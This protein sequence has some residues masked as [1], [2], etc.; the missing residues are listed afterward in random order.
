MGKASASWESRWTGTGAIEYVRSLHGDAVIEE[1]LLGEEFTLQAFV[2]G[3]HLVPMPLVQDHKRAF[4]GD[5]GPNT[6]G[7]GSYT[8]PDHMMPFVSRLGLQPRRSRS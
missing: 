3:N 4:E 2:D 1:R 7:M 8:L 6:G 5:T